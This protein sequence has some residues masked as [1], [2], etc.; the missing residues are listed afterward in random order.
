M[1]T[2][3]ISLVQL[4]HGPQAAKDRRT[5]AAC[6]A[7]QGRFCPAVGFAG[8]V[9]ASRQANRMS[10]MQRGRAHLLMPQAHTGHLLKFPNVAA[11]ITGPSKAML[12][13]H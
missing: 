5:M 7:L 10:A 13:K 2:W 11:T 6:L 8:H 9:C 12:I 1:R 4:L 3:H